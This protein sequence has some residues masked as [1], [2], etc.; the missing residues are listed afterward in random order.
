MN[1]YYPPE[2]KAEVVAMALKGEVTKRQVAEDVGIS[3]TTLHR[4]IRQYEVDEGQR[5]GTTTEEHKELLQ[6]RKD[7][8][9]LEQ[10]NEILRRAAAYFAK[11]AL[12]K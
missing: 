8:R 12:P 5:A 1:K 9:R 7:K 3:E 11:D 10:E 6:L 4:W 2:F